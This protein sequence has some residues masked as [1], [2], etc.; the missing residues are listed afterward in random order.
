MQ[1]HSLSREL[2][3]LMLGQV[4]D[5]GSK[6]MPPSDLSMEALLHQVQASLALHV[7]EA[8]DHSAGDLEQAQQQL[9]D[10]EL[11]QEGEQSLPRVRTHLQKGLAL[12]EQALNRLSAS[13]ELPRLLV[14]ADQE[15]VRRGAIERAQAVLQQLIATV[16]HMWPVAILT[17][18]RIN[19][20]Q[21]YRPELFHKMLENF[22]AARR[23]QLPRVENLQQLAQLENLQQ[24]VQVV[25][26][27]WQLPVQNL[28]R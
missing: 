1:S 9:L 16:L 5:R 25:M 2:A 11:Q 3:L 8:L 17:F 4:D 18:L 6:P 21:H 10:S 19:L 23:R 22:P 13:L 14:L 7:R 20:Q 15:A 26:Q 12:A 24:V 28:K 27:Q